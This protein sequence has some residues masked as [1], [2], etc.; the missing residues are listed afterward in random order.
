M[1]RQRIGIDVGGTHTDVV[2]AQA[3]GG[4]F[5]IEKLPSTPHDPSIAAL[6]GVRRLLESGVSPQDVEFFAHG[7]TATT[8]ALLEMN[9]AKVGLLVNAGMRGVVEVQSQGREG[10]SPFDHFFRRPEPLARPLLTR[11]IAGRMDYAGAQVEPLDE[12]AVRAAAR[13]LAARGV[14]SF[15]V[16]FLFS[17]M[18]DAHERRA[19]ELIREEA[20][21]AFV[22]CSSRVSPRIRE[23]PR[24]STTL[25]NAYLAP[26]L[27]RYCGAISDGLDAMGVATPQRFLMQSNGG[28]TPLAVDAEADAV[29]TLL[30]GPAAG[31]RAASYLLGHAQGW[32]NLVTMDIGGTSCDVA[33]IEAGEP[34]EQSESVIDGRVVSA[35]ALDIAT[36]AAGGGSIAR[37]DSAGMP[38]VGPRSAGATPGP[39]CYGR[40]GEEP[41]V[42]DANLLCGALN[43][44]YFLGGAMKLDPEAARRA[45]ARIAAPMGVDETTAACGIVRLVNAHMTDAIRIEAAKKG[46]DLSDHTL[47]PF[48]GAGPV[49]AAQV[50]EDLGVPRVLVPPNPGAFSALGLL[51]SDVRHDLMRSEMA[52]LATLAPAHAE[53]CFAQL[54]ARARAQFAAEGLEAAQAVF[55]RAMDMRYAGQGY[56][57]RVELDGLNAPLDEAA[58][59]ALRARFHAQHAA[60]HGHAAPDAAVEAVSYRLRATAAMPKYRPRPRPL[61]AREAPAPVASRRLVLGPERALDARVWRRDDLFPGWR[62]SGPAIIEQ[63]DSTTIVPDGWSVRCD[64]WDNL[65]LER[66][67]DAR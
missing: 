23:W 43:P 3:D 15:A 38:Q 45:M 56:E 48:G 11:E 4:E 14:V 59:A 18:N 55:A 19:Q 54:E 61:E 21:G 36:V 10:W 16:C 31:V 26:V 63:R 29:R 32:R 66:S 20:P 28:V 2:L 35:P 24:F 50:A 44:D 25:L 12:E 52:D 40:G 27:A 42:T 51:C 37:L 64:E 7:T 34:L 57:L 1:R 33:F 60:V 46:V 9:G 58:L 67:R 53:A 30:S 8:N 6:A 22:S 17:F 65:V 41:T 47:V 13:E 39:A 49:H 5:R 62:E